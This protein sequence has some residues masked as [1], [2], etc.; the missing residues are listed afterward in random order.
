MLPVRT[1]TGTGGVTD[2]LG[3][4]GLVC[5]KMAERVAVVLQEDEDRRERHE[6]DSHRG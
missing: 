4:S 6:T 5:E 2:A 1:Q 3:L